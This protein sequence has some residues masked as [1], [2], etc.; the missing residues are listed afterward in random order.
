MKNL[1]T[2]GLLFCI[3]IAAFA[4]AARASELD[5]LTVFTFGAPVEVPGKIVLPAGT[6]VFKLLDGS[7]DRNVVQI[8]DEQQSKIYATIL[9]ISIERLEPTYKT[10]VEFYETDGGPQNALKAWFYPGDLFGQQFVYPKE[11]A[12]ELAKAEKQR[13]ILTSSHFTRS[14]EQR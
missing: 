7:A 12:A 11:R 2:I 14:T 1:R 5:K 3:T 6:Y 10:V 4:F 9:T 13:I 8:F